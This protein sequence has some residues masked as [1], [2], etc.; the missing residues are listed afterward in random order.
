M[1]LC[2]IYTNMKRSE[3]AENIEERL[4]RGIALATNSSF[5]YQFVTLHVNSSSFMAGS[6]EPA[7]ICQIYSATIKFDED[8]VIKEYHRKLFDLL[9]EL[10]GLRKNRILVEMLKVPSAMARIGS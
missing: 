10:T 8:S 2:F 1:P 7:I 4:A 9:R 5:A 6:H 3:L